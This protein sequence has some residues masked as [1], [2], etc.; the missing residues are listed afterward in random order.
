[1]QQALEERLYALLPALYRIRDGAHGEPLR[2]LLAVVE[3]ELRPLEAEIARLYENWFIETCEDWVIPYIGDLLGVRLRHAVPMGG[4]YSLR[5]YVANTLGYRRRKGTAVVLE[6]V[7][8]DVT[9]WPAHA[10]EFFER[11]SAT[12]HVNHARPHCHATLDLRAPGPLELLHGPFERAAHTVEVRHSRTGAGRYNIPN[13]GLFIW[14]QQAYFVSRGSAHPRTPD[15]ALEFTFHPLGHDAPLF[16]CPE[17]APD[18]PRLADEADVPAPLRRRALWDEWRRLG[19]APDAGCAPG[20]GAIG[21]QP[22]F[23]A[24]FAVESGGT[25]IPPGQLAI[26]DLSEWP[27]L[28]E[29]ACCAVDPELG[30]IAFPLGSAPTDIRVSYAYGCPGDLGGGPYPRQDSV[31]LWLNPRERAATWQCGVARDPEVA[32]RTPDQK[33]PLATLAAA[34]RDWNAHVADNPTAFGIIAV[35]DSSTYEES[36]AGEDAIRMPRGSRLAIV[37]ADWPVVAGPPRSRGVG[38]VV[39]DK[40]R[41]HILGNIEVTPEDGGD[42]PGELILDGLLVEG[43]LHVGPG[44][45][46]RLL[47]HHTTLVPGRGGLTVAGDDSGRNDRLTVRLWR[48][49]CGPIALAESVPRLEV[50][51]S[52]IDGLGEGL[53]G[54]AICAKGSDVQ[55]Q[56]STVFG[57]GYVRRLEAS[58]SIFDGA[59]VCE[60][61]QSGCV[62]FSYLG[63]GSKTPRRHRCQPGVAGESAEER[64]GLRPRFVSTRYGA[65]GYAQLSRVC[66]PEISCGAG[67]ETEMGAFHFLMQPQR[68]ANLRAAL[69]EYLRF[70]LEAGMWSES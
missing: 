31:D 10:V 67:E 50:T 24:M 55:L 18:L 58:D 68:E 61:R 63:A 49:V 2:A 41:P 42:E 22:A 21:R 3:S 16:N 19:A 60:R 32:S 30:R 36:L 13:V 35:M 45:L 5:A 44:G 51:D 9:G 39:A 23:R 53:E 29:G 7:A 66:A 46:D 65:P 8:R 34:V 6:Q 15:S 27:P 38:Q 25:P 48:T 37:A 62:R 4:V 47:L 43:S 69:D 12:Q 64:L 70:G 56:A 11:L 33:P 54:T 52:V 26:A 28:P 1:M 14:R 40:L 57:A 59:V 17:H 20:P